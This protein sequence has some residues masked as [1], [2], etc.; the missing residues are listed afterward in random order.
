MVVKH[1][2]KASAA[3]ESYLQAWKGKDYINMTKHCTETWLE[4]KAIIGISILEHWY[5]K[6]LQGFKIIS[7]KQTGSATLDFMVA[8]Q[9]P[10]EDPPAVATTLLDGRDGGLDEVLVDAHFDTH[11]GLGR[12]FRH[13][14][15]GRVADTVHLAHGHPV[16]VGICEQRRNR[17]Q[18]FGRDDGLDHPHAGL[19][20]IL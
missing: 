1:K 15:A 13:G 17:R 14:D 10:G 11:H 12:D 5:E 18:A 19:P 20:G 7:A 8:V 4:D 3:L 16:D 9:F 2:K 6:D